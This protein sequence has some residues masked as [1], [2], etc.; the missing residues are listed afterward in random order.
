MH[1]PGG[2]DRRFRVEGGIE[3]NG[4][5]PEGRG[6]PAEK[7]LCE[8][9][10]S[11]SPGHLY[12]LMSRICSLSPYWRSL[13]YSRSWWAG[14]SLKDHRRFG[15]SRGGFGSALLPGDLASLGNLTLTLRT[16]HAVSVLSS[17]LVCHYSLMT[18]RNWCFQLGAALYCLHPTKS[19]CH[20]RARRQQPTQCLRG[21]CPLTCIRSSQSR[22]QILRSRIL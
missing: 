21:Q 2:L 1:R 8:P 6:F 9:Q 13:V 20:C 4:E 19:N 17:F 16:Q 5:V 15:A 3:R 10:H 12:F 7:Y 18:R 22:V 11:M 14:P